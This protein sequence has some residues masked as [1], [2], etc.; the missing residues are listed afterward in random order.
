MASPETKPASPGR[1]A[2]AE[3]VIDKTES[4]VPEGAITRRADNGLAAV[5][6]EP[7]PATILAV[8]VEKG[9][10]PAGMEKLV[11]LY[12]RLEDRKAAQEFAAALAMF[13]SECPTI[14]KTST[15]EIV[16]KSG[17][18]YS[19][20]FADL[21]E[22]AETARPWLHK[23][24]LSYG[25]DTEMQNGV[26][27]CVCHLRHRNGHSVPSRYPVPKDMGQLSGFH[28]DI[29]ALTVARRMTLSLALGITTADPAPER[30]APVDDGPK[31]SP[32]QAAN[33]DALL[34]EVVNRDA[35]R[36]ASF[37]RY[38]GVR[39]LKDIPASQFKQAVTALEEKRREQGG[40][41]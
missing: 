36:R 37:L 40:K 15:A 21:P 30:G 23:H 10:D 19:Y 8:A 27:Y 28:K 13:Q 2:R 20:N 33:L 17:V 11:D 26:E 6:A 39:D 9:I 4:Q 14:P 18:K 29:G 22:I 35:A 41:A 31:V 25:W 7:S 1:G 16:T 24:G 5:P 38:M 3:T 32:E 34:D 12:L